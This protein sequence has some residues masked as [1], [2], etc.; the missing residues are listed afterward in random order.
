MFVAGV[1]V[2]KFVVDV[3]K[4]PMRYLGGFKNVSC[5]TLVLFW[6]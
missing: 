3:K 2:L 1:K 4:P 6:Y 5:E